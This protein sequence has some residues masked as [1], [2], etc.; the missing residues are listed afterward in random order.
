[1]ITLGIETSCDDTAFAL[2][3]D[4]KEV[5]SSVISSQVDIH[6]TFGGVVPEIAARRHLEVLQPLFV[7]AL[8][9]ASITVAEIDRIAVTQGPGLIGGVLVGAAFAR[10]LAQYKSC[11]LIPVN[12]VKA[13]VYGAL[14]G[15]EGKWEDAFPALALVVS[16]GH[17]HLYYLKEAGKFDL[18]SQLIKTLRPVGV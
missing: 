13:H 11:P 18:R 3:K 5:L 9:D 8:R 15:I 16:G 12:H 14:L 10:G 2:L 6:Q 17:T 7:K 1:M 4:S